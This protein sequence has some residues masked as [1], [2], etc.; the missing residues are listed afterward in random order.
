MGAVNCK[1]SGS[2]VG[3][4][5][6]GAC[7]IMASKTKS[8]KVEYALRC[9]PRRAWGHAPGWHSAHKRRW[10]FW[11]DG[12]AIISFRQ[13]VTAWVLK[14]LAQRLEIFEIVHH[15]ASAQGKPRGTTHLPK[16]STHFFGLEQARTIAS[17]RAALDCKCL[18]LARVYSIAYCLQVSRGNSLHGRRRPFAGLSPVSFAKMC[19]L[20]TILR[21]ASFCIVCPSR[22]TSITL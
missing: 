11:S 21:A 22:P 6:R 16:T 2:S 8:I 1:S 3:H 9:R 20:Y 19:I 5:G 4:E 13:Q 14:L 18:A 17:L 12:K 7:L 15:N 10:H